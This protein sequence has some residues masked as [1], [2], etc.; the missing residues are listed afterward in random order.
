M[1]EPPECAAA[2]STAI[3]MPRSADPHDI[4]QT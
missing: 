4:A 1:T 3:H 2:P